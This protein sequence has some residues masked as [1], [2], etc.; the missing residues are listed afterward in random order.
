MSIAIAETWFLS[1]RVEPQKP[2]FFRKSHED[3]KILVET[4]FLGWLGEVQK[5]GFFGKSHE[6]A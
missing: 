2:G 3:A 5:P 6:D 4:R 1:T